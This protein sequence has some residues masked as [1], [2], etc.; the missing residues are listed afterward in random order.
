MSAKN[1][2]DELNALDQSAAEAEAKEREY[3]END[4]LVPEIPEDYEDSF[5]DILNTYDG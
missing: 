4:E 3:L 1:K 5:S 2:K